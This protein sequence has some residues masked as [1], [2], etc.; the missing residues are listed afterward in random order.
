LV[1]KFRNDKG[2]SEVWSPYASSVQ[3]L[4]DRI[5]VYGT[6]I[7]ENTWTGFPLRT[8]RRCQDPMF[9]IANKIAYQD[10]MVLGT[11]TE[12]SSEKYLGASCWFDVVGGGE[13]DSQVIKEEIE[14]L[15]QKIAELRETYQD[16]VYVIS[17]FK[18]VA[19]ECDRVLRERFN[20][21][22]LL[23]GTIHTFQGKEAD[24]V[25]LVLGSQPNREGSRR[26]ASEKP[27]ML[28]VAVTRAKKRCYIIGNKKLWI[29]Q[30]IFAVADEIL[31]DIATITQTL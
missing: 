14:F 21:P 27:N 24:V 26:W 11:S 19:K 5:S 23:C 7:D 20:D 3:R 2:I 6:Q 1:N 16:N 12:K 18:A 29:K 22:K 17:P 4:A 31:C 10:Q 30:P 28:N 8:H 9:S 25:F 13:G 15:V